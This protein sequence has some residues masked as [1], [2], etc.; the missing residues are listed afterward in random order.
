MINLALIGNGKWGKNYLKEIKKISGANIKYIRTY[1]YLSLAG[2][3]DID[4]IIIA[5]PDNT[6]CEILTKF[7]NHYILVEKPV[8][9]SFRDILKI[10]NPRVM[11][12]HIYLYNLALI[13]FLNDIDDLKTIDFILRN[14]EN[15]K[16]A[17]PLWHLAIHGVA[18]AVYLRGEPDQIIAR[19]KNKNLFIELNYNSNADLTYRIEVGW[20][21]ANKERIIKAEGSKVFVFDDSQKQNISPLENECRSFIR[22]INGND[23]ISDLNHIKKVTKVLEKIDALIR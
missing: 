1:D 4:G 2:K 13:N 8:V 3:K 21:Y 12:G 22:F 15:V 17:T 23:S 11:A 6:H 9:T 7:P 16:D 19:E 5:T 14:N 18:L 10:N 20:N